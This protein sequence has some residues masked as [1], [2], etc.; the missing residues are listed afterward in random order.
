MTVFSTDCDQAPATYAGA[1]L[2][3]TRRTTKRSA[4]QGCRCRGCR[5]FASSATWGYI[6]SHSERRHRR[7][8]QTWARD[9]VKAYRGDGP[10]PE[11]PPQK[12][13]G[14]YAI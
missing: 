9:L 6:K 13:G 8:V 11:E 5:H 7:A 3:G 10:L 14:Y 2:I 12:V 4:S 1:D